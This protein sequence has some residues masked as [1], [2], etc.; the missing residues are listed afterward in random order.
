M[1]QSDL[2]KLYHTNLRP[3]CRSRPF[4]FNMIR[5]L[6]Q[7]NPKYKLSVLREEKRSRKRVKD[8]TPVKYRTLISVGKTGFPRHGSLPQK[9]RSINTAHETLQ[10]S[11]KGVQ[12]IFQKRTSDQNS[13]ELKKL[14]ESFR[15]KYGA[16]INFSVDLKVDSKPLSSTDFFSKNRSTDQDFLKLMKLE[17]KRFKTEYLGAGGAERPIIV[18][19]ESPFG[20]SWKYSENLKIKAYLTELKKKRFADHNSAT[21]NINISNHDSWSV[22]KVKHMSGE[23]RKPRKKFGERVPQRP[24]STGFYHKTKAEILSRRAR[25]G[26]GQPDFS[27]LRSSSHRPSV[28]PDATS[29]ND[30]WPGGARVPQKPQ[31]G[32]KTNV[33]ITEAEGS[34]RPKTT[35]LTGGGGRN[36]KPWRR[37]KTSKSTKRGEKVKNVV[38]QKASKTTL[39][40]LNKSRIVNTQDFY[41]VLTTNENTRYFDNMIRPASSNKQQS[42]FQRLG[43]GQLVVDGEYILEQRKKV[44]EE[45]KNDASF[46]Q[47]KSGTY[48]HTRNRTMSKSVSRASSMVKTSP[49]KYKTVTGKAGFDRKKAKLKL[50]KRSKSGTENSKNHY[51]S[52]HDSTIFY[53][54]TRSKVRNIKNLA[55]KNFE[56]YQKR[57]NKRRRKVQNGQKGD[58]TGEKGAPQTGRKLTGRQSSELASGRKIASKTQERLWIRHQRYPELEEYSDTGS[59]SPTEAKLP[60]KPPKVKTQKKPKTKKSGKKEGKEGDKKPKKIRDNL[61]RKNYREKYTNTEEER[62]FT[63]LKNLKSEMKKAKKMHHLGGKMGKRLRNMKSWARKRTFKSHTDQEFEN[64]VRTDD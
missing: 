36:K 9:S 56:N 51:G 2:K 41:T 34:H 60:K 16:N 40:A 6:R 42:G 58:Q 53:N 25:P 22:M 23:Q 18:D 52:I 14:R 19:R 12:E 54:E 29:K 20:L 43:G 45:L 47:S 17:Q 33:L 15:K 7:S 21:N 11:M 26:F 30:G 13:R 24:S 4:S 32:S 57:V 44:L 37:T 10:S 62:D 38:S 39:Y 1:E 8:H 28:L 35:A 3:I 64:Y 50:K 59:R 49:R 46:E 27:D 55:I 5:K 31:N 63:N 61:I 48:F